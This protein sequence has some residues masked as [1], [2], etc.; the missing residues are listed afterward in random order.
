MKSTCRDDLNDELLTTVLQSVTREAGP[1]SVQTS[2]KRLRSFSSR[3][4]LVSGAQLRRRRAAER[5]RR[6]LSPWS[7]QGSQRISADT[8]SS[9]LATPDAADNEEQTPTTPQQQGPKDAFDWRRTKT[10]N[11]RYEKR[12]IDQATPGA[13]NLQQCKPKG[14]RLY[15]TADLLQPPQFV[16]RQSRASLY[17]EAQGFAN[18]SMDSNRRACAAHTSHHHANAMN[19]SPICYPGSRDGSGMGLPMDG[20]PAQETPTHR[21]DSSR[22]KGPSSGSAGW[23]G[24]NNCNFGSSVFAPPQVSSYRRLSDF[25]PQ[26]ARVL[27]RKPLGHGYGAARASDMGVGLADA[28]DAH[29]RGYHYSAYPPCRS[30]FTG[31]LNSHP[32]GLMNAMQGYEGGIDR[33]PLRH[34]VNDNERSHFLSREAERIEEVEELFGRSSHPY[35]QWYGQECAPSSVDVFHRGSDCYRDV[36]KLPGPRRPPASS[37]LSCKRRNNDVE[38][39][40]PVETGQP[41]SQPECSKN[42]LAGGDA[43]RGCEKQKSVPWPSSGSFLRF[44]S[45]L[46]NAQSDSH[47]GLGRDVEASGAARHASG[48]APGCS[49]PEGKRVDEINLVNG[50]RCMPFI[51]HTKTYL[52][53]AAG[54]MMPDGRDA[55][56]IAFNSHIGPENDLNISDPMKPSYTG[57]R[58]PGH[59]ISNYS[60]NRVKTQAQC[61]LNAQPAYQQS[62]E[63]QHVRRMQ[64][65]IR[66]ISDRSAAL[67]QD[68]KNLVSQ[69]PPATYATKSGNWTSSDLMRDHRQ[70]GAPLRQ[71]FR[72]PQSLDRLSVENDGRAWHAHG[73]LYDE[74]GPKPMSR[75][76]WKEPSVVG[77]SIDG[78]MKSDFLGLPRPS[79]GQY[80]H[81][82]PPN[83]ASH[84]SQRP[85]RVANG[86]YANLSDRSREHQDPRLVWSSTRKA[87]TTDEGRW[88]Q[89]A[90]ESS[91]AARKRGEMASGGG[92]ASRRGSLTVDISGRS[93]FSPQRVNV[94]PGAYDP[95]GPETMAPTNCN[96]RSPSRA[97]PTEC[98]RR[99]PVHQRQGNDPESDGRAFTSTSSHHTFLDDRNPSD[100]GRARHPDTFEVPGTFA[101]TSLSG[102][103]RNVEKVAGDVYGTASGDGVE[104]DLQSHGAQPGR[105]RTKDALTRVAQNRCLSS[106]EIKRQSTGRDWNPRVQPSIMLDP[107]SSS[108][109]DFVSS[110]QILFLTTQRVQARA[111]DPCSWII[112]YYGKWTSR[113]FGRVSSGKHFSMADSIASY[114]GIQKGSNFARDPKEIAQRNRLLGYVELGNAHHSA[115]T[116]NPANPAKVDTDSDGVTGSVDANDTSGVVAGTLHLDR[117]IGRGGTSAVFAGRLSS[118]PGHAQ[119]AHEEGKEAGSGC[120]PIDEPFSKSRSDPLT[121]HPLNVPVVVKILQQKHWKCALAELVASAAIVHRM[122][123]AAVHLTASTTGATEADSF[124]LKK[125]AANI[126][127]QTSPSTAA[128]ELSFGKSSGDTDSTILDSNFGSTE[129]IGRVNKRREAFAEHKTCSKASEPPYAALHTNSVDKMAA[130]P[131]VRGTAW[132]MPT[133]LHLFWNASEPSPPRVEGATANTL[134]VAGGGTGGSSNPFEHEAATEDGRDTQ[135]KSKAPAAI[136]PLI[137]QPRFP[138]TENP[139][140]CSLVLRN[141][142]EGVPLLSWLNSVFVK[143]RRKPSHEICVY[144]AFAVVSLVRQLH[145]CGLLHGDV[146]PDNFVLLPAGAEYPFRALFEHVQRQHPLLQGIMDSPPVTVAGIDFGRSLDVREAL[147]DVVFI[148]D[149][150]VSDFRC[151]PMMEKDP[152]ETQIDLTGLAVTIY[153]IL[154]LKYPKIKKKHREAQTR[155]EHDMAARPGGRQVWREE[156]GDDSRLHDR[157]CPAT[158]RKSE[159]DANGGAGHS[160]QSYWFGSRIRSNPCQNQFWLDILD[161]LINFNPVPSSDGHT[162]SASC[163]LLQ[164]IEGDLV[165]VFHAKKHDRSQIKAQISILASELRELRQFVDTGIR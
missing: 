103:A 123:E 98:P 66:H 94:V 95:K 39:L 117:L 18:D 31:A 3:K 116:H 120:Q 129:V 76:S 105:H 4:V 90:V 137:A 21:Q 102:Y 141:V 7:R 86:E 118:P 160:R 28:N 131:F 63:R 158:A 88:K 16:D 73:S 54:S 128:S 84:P 67:L 162:T 133:E 81:G 149:T 75:E 79:V 132:L 119:Q 33:R 126:T 159:E 154:S 45:G 148:G 70:L 36:E 135:L 61:R 9:Q 109:R 43:L 14:T 58:L 20:G 136:D 68:A 24:G 41:S 37:A 2:E 11:A 100:R 38:P 1:R 114:L 19:T 111:L 10:P 122:N 153:T 101:T 113:A 115:Q 42:A 74:P 163:M 49:I 161:R 87:F 80:C 130:S 164:H 140:L 150:Q 145:A 6:M 17:P 152:W 77:G 40:Y 56:S 110:R 35:G 155:E 62:D 64:T 51:P 59:S 97:T 60:P 15:K 46:N 34:E 26:L 138:E 69:G 91:N 53:A 151:P 147:R 125:G 85:N 106:L 107:Y 93:H 156:P 96:P 143:R 83:N 13:P 82:G 146:K 78:L 99:V 65:H 121:C 32:D 55:S 142:N 30:Q 112:N 48:T 52:S 127:V 27:P 144:F 71:S 89:D 50:D 124:N 44:G 22:R 5:P 57:N 92:R 139:A 12:C 47:A 23:H 165:D 25:D 108:A 104:S 29:V 134:N 157:L 72:I 8:R